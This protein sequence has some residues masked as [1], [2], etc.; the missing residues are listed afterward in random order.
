MRKTKSF[1]YIFPMLKEII[2]FRD[3]VSNVFIGDESYPGLDGNIFVLYKFSGKQEFL[4]YEE[5]MKTHDLYVTAYDP[6]ESHLMMVLK[7]PQQHKKDFD[8]LIE[9]KYSKVSEGY[10]NRILTFHAISK[11]HPVADVLYKTEAAF[12]K[13]EDELENSIPRD[14][15]VS[16]KLDKAREFYNNTYKI[17]SV[18]KP[19][20]EFDN[21]LLRFNTREGE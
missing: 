16:S 21:K 20:E 6:D 9:S 7:V 13:L 18:I 11:N 10:K 14:Q 5:N 17:M 19:N 4:A 12:R 8:L 3:L 1:T 15:E 2:K